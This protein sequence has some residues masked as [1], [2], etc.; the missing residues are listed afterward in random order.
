MLAWNYVVTYFHHKE[1]IL[2]F[3]VMFLILF[4]LS[5]FGQ[6]LKGSTNKK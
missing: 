6:I 2:N 1:L 4:I 3:W 5:V